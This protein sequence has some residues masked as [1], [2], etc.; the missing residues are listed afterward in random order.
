[1][2]CAGVAGYLLKD[3]PAAEL[4]AAVRLAQAGVVQFDPAAAA[5][6]TTVL[7]R[8]AAFPVRTPPMRPRLRQPRHR[9]LP[10]GQPTGPRPRT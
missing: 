4:A 10:A 3:R 6:L 1:M 7:D 2:W 5:R 9:L 8:A